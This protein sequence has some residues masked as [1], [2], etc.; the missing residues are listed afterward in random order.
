MP[1]D[2]AN[3]K[4]SVPQRRAVGLLCAAVCGSALLA[5]PVADMKLPALP[6]IAGIYGASA[7]MIDFATFWLLMSAHRPSR[8][9]RIVAA[10]YLYAGL[11]AVLHV[12][13]FPGALMADTTVIGSTNSV[14]WLFICWRAGFP[15]FILW[16]V[17]TEIRP[18]R[19]EPERGPAPT[20]M[21]LVAVAA[22]LAAA[23]S[24]SDISAFMPGP[25]GP[26][27][28]YFDRVVSFAGVAVAAVTLLLMLRHG[29]AWRALYLWLMLVLVSETVGAWF[30]THGGGRYTVAWYGAR[31]EG[32]VASAIVLVLLATHFRE[33]QRRL[34]AAVEALS[35]RTDALQAEI[36]HREHAERALAHSQKLDAVGQLAAGL[37][38]DINNFMQVVST[39]S[40]L[41]RRKSGAGVPAVSADVD[42]IQR[43]VRKAEQL[44]RQLL[45]FAGRRP[46]QPQG[47]LL[48]RLVPE[49]LEAFQP[50]L[51]ARA[52]VAL[53]LA[54]DAWPVLVDPTE[55]EIALTNLL[56]NASDAIAPGGT[57]EVSVANRVRFEPGER[58]ERVV[59]EVQDHGSGI[60]PAVLERVFEPFFTTKPPGKGTGLGLSQ[61]YAFARASGGDVAIDSE[62]GRGTTVRIE[63]P[64]HH[65]AVNE[66][67][68]AASQA[69]TTPAGTVVLLVDDNADV[70]DAT[71]SLLE[72]AGLAVRTAT[73]SVAALALLD[74]GLRPD[75]LLSD[76]VLG[77]DLDG[78]ALA[79]R[80]RERLPGIR[81]VLATGYSAAAADAKGQ[82]FAVLQKPYEAGQL[83][84]AVGG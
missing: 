18:P 69:S 59:L 71:A 56:T 54:A 22:C 17:L 64:R 19:P 70:L 61:V 63:L 42:V 48:Q 8:A 30:S 41:I 23:L 34:G 55:L 82:G 28:G 40:E 66:A 3:Q 10:A 75:V 16:A 73:G 57:V 62:P 25:Q 45:L 12:L 9:L 44:T 78:V 52:K 76:I 80:V 24:A 11:M 29:L 37:A 51:G 26:R 79:Q 35:E 67:A 21:A 81:V 14:S 6:H 33:L 32:L 47:L 31:V 72:Q 58:S 15:L 49:F 39:R 84:K 36:Q 50:V 5:L 60:P 65:A 53:A 77:G 38:H 43:N 1:F 20:M 83:L 2:V 13:S 7:A 4:A 46:L 74:G 27:F 68:A